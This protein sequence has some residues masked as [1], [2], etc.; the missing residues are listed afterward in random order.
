MRLMTRGLGARLT[1][2]VP[3]RL[4]VRAVKVRPCDAGVGIVWLALL[5][6]GAG[7][8]AHAPSVRQTPTSGEVR[9][10]TPEVQGS[11]RIGQILTPEAH[12]F[13]HVV[14]EAESALP[15]PRG[16][17]VFEIYDQ[18]RGVLV[19]RVTAP[20]RRVVERRSFTIE[21]AAIEGSRLGQYLLEVTM[22]DAVD[23]EGISLWAFDGRVGEDALIVNGT[24]AFAELAFETGSAPVWGRLLRHL[25]EPRTGSAGLAMLFLAF[26]L[27][28]VA[29]IV[30]L[31]TISCAGLTPAADGPSVTARRS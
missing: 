10:L 14:I 5:L 9:F 7:L 27:A 31:R 22:P 17:V 15:D 21:F 29:V 30:L 3:L 11:R 23:G 1:D 4:T 28:N 12:A 26:L 18:S 20:A 16:E 13:N 19:R 8:L 6:V 2:L 25:R 24:H